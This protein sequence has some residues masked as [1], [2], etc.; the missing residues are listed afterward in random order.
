MLIFSAFVLACP[1]LGT[2]TASYP[3]LIRRSSRSPP[4]PTLGQIHPGFGSPPSVDISKARAR[5]HPLHVNEDIYVPTASAQHPPLPLPTALHGRLVNTHLHLAPHTPTPALSPAHRPAVS[6]PVP[7]RICTR[8]ALDRRLV[9]PDIYIYIRSWFYARASGI[10]DQDRH[11]NRPWDPCRS[12]KTRHPTQANDPPP[13]PRMDP[14]NTVM[15]TRTCTS[16]PFLVQTW[17]AT[18]LV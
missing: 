6:P 16:S 18:S 11:E 12:S 5:I 10:P 13:S 1:N 8:P 2:N 4:P 17:F 15:N 9:L 3:D 14:I 7:L